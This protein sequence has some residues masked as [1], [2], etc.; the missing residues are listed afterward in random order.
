MRVRLVKLR[1]NNAESWQKAAA[2]LSVL[3]MVGSSGKE[4]NVAI[5][6]ELGSKTNARVPHM[7]ALL[8]SRALP[9]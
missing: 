3:L 6:S 7:E 8:P 1:S 4:G 9:T 2:L 5:T